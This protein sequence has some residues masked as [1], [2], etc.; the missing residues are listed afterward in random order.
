MNQ[1]TISYS[2]GNPIGG[3]K[4]FSM[5]V[6]K[7]GVHVAICYGYPPKAVFKQSVYTALVGRGGFLSKLN[8]NEPEI[9]QLWK[10]AQVTGLFQP[11]GR[12]LKVLINRELNIT[13]I[14]I[15]VGWLGKVASE[16]EKHEL[17]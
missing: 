8:V 11:A 17:K 7:N 10:E 15:L 14:Q 13:E 4:G 12:E 6:D 5:N 16:I 2:W 1:H 9:E 3:T